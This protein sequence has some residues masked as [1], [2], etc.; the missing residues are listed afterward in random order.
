[1]K[2]AEALEFA[3]V[4][5]RGERLQ[6]VGVRA[7]GVGYPPHGVVRTAPGLGQ[8][9]RIE[10]DIPAPGTAWVEPRVAQE[11]ALAM[12][13]KIEVGSAAFSVTRILT[14]EPGRSANFFALS[15][16]VL[17]PLT[18][19]PRTKVVQ[20]GSRVSYRYAFAGP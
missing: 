13:D 20:P 17:I 2:A 15:P 16:R 3:S 7:V 1:M 8:P 12:G 10:T 5:I 18:D 9:D 19:V 11:L 14:D 4:V 6:I